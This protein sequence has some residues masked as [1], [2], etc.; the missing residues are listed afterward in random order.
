MLAMTAPV[1]SAETLRA[2][3]AKAG[4]LMDHLTTLQQAG[5]ERGAA[6]LACDEKGEHLAGEFAYASR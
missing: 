4:R 6:E 1:D 5:G 3:A 2:F